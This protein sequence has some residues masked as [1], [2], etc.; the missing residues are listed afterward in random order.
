DG[1]RSLGGAAH[2]AAPRS[3]FERRRQRGRAGLRREAR[4]GLAG[5]VALG[6]RAAVCREHGSPEAVKVEELPSPSLAGGQVRV[7]V[8]AAAVNFPDVLI[9]ANQ[10]QIKVP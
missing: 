6:M 10:Y 9:V 4:A 8:A 1:Y 2:R 5:E 7:Q 3:F